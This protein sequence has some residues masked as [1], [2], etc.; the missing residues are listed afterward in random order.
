MALENRHIVAQCFF[1]SFVNEINILEL[2]MKSKYAKDHSNL[3]N[4]GHQS[5]KSDKKMLV[6]FK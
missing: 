4:N 5:L 2:Q 3:K 6:D 1:R